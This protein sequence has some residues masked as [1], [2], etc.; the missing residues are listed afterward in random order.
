LMAMERMPSEVSIT[1]VL[2]FV[3]L[4]MVDRERLSPR[5]CGAGLRAQTHPI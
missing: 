5:D 3:L 2:I 1:R 4:M